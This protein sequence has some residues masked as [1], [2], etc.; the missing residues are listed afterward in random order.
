MGY[1][2]PPLTAFVNVALVAGNT[3]GNV[4]AAPGAANAY[5]IVGG[6]VVL[7]QNSTA[8]AS[9]FIADNA[10]APTALHRFGIAPNAPFAVM[11]IP[12]PGLLLPANT[13]IIYSVTATAA[14]GN[15]LIVVYYYNEV[16]D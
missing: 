11:S 14:S 16:I 7:S 13:P 8:N 2:F 12:E 10:G 9:G 4:L 3:S 1:L 6:H 15:A 5:R